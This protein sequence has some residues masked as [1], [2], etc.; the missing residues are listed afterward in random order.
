MAL[1]AAE[2]HEHE[3]QKLSTDPR[4]LMETAV[5]KWTKIADAMAKIGC[6]VYPR[7]IGA[8]RNKWQTLFGEYK[9]IFDYKGRTGNNEEYFR[10]ASKRK[11]EL[12]LPA[13]FCSS[14]Y[15]NMER[16]LSQRP[17]LNP[18]HQ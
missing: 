17:C 14:Q 11:K 12:R 13:N 5:Q 8:C 3:L 16:F 6:S 1:I 4:E 9:K 18:P 2:K 7:G 15:W 10:M